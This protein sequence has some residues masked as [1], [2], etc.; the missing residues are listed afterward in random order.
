MSEL[1]F[2]TKI[3]EY[4]G[5]VFARIP[6][7]LADKLELKTGDSAKVIYEDGVWKIVIGGK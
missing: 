5:S 1:D 6:K 4:G 2:D 7:W 3:A